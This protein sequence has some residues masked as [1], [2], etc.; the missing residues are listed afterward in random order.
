MGQKFDAPT[1]YVTN[2]NIDHGLHDSMVHFPSTEEP[3]KFRAV[4][5]FPRSLSRATLEMEMDLTPGANAILN[6]IMNNRGQLNFGQERREYRCVW[7]GTAN[8][9]ENRFCSQCGGPRGWVL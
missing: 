4:Q 3:G 6:A 2:I 9:I 1:L 7:C 5:A 8:G